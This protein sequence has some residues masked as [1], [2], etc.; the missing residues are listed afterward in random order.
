MSRYAGP[1]EALA[2]W[3]YRHQPPRPI[4]RAVG[5]IV[6]LKR[7]WEQTDIRNLRIRLNAVRYMMG[8]HKY[9]ALFRS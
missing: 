5:F 6:V 7:C 4:Y 8:V 1:I 2:R 9:G 3:A